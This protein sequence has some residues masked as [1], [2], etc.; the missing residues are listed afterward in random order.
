MEFP[1]PLRTSINTMRSSPTGQPASGI[2]S[3]QLLTYT[4]RWLFKCIYRIGI[5]TYIARGRWVSTRYTSD[6]DRSFAMQ[7]NSKQYTDGSSEINQ[8]TILIV[9]PTRNLQ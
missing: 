9:C 3:L 5:T 2:F 7:F 6:H 8:P 1:P 4:A